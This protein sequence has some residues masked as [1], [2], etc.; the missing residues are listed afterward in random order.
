[1]ATKIIPKKSS[2]AGKVPLASQLD[3][4]ELAI[5]LADAKL[6]TKR[7]DGT[8][9]LL[10]PTGGGGGGGS[11]VT[12]SETAPLSPSSGDLWWDSAAGQLLIYYSDSDSSQWVEANSPGTGPQGP[13]GQ[14][15]PTG[16][17]TGQ[18]L[19]KTSNTNYDTQ[20]VT[21]STGGGSEVTWL[22]YALDGAE[23]S[24]ASYTYTSGTLT[25]V[26]DYVNGQ[27]RTTTYTYSAGLLSAVAVTYLG[28][29]KTTAYN[30]T[31]GTLTSTT[32]T[33]V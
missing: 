18:V 6:Y 1:M 7:T 25:Q 5:N 28:V 33:E 21:V 19:A 24:N 20:W 16:G 4:G 31:G 8:V 14:G 12:V 22:R 26:S 32:T 17:T 15:V 11:S 30:Y 23:G 10:T 2:E 3:P 29:T 9:I 13:T 27:A